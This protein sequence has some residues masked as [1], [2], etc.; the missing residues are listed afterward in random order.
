M[1]DRAA[2]RKV[3]RSAK[4]WKKSKLSHQYRYKPC[5]DTSLCSSVDVRVCW[6]VSLSPVCRLCNKLKALQAAER[7]LE[8]QK[9]QHHVAM[10][11]LLLQTQSLEQALKTERH[12]VTEEKWVQ[13]IPRHRDSRISTS[14]S[15]STLMWNLEK[16]RRWSADFLQTREMRNDSNKLPILSHVKNR[17]LLLWFIEPHGFSSGTQCSLSYYVKISVKRKIETPVEC[18]VG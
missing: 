2:W 10:D 11:K 9:K 18:H 3:S 5:V 17:N 7:E 13:Y 14:C 12:V 8:Q 16:L 4:Y 6:C 1:R 15:V